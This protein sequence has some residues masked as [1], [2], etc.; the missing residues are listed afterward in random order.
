[1]PRKGTTLPYIL[2]EMTAQYMDCA[3]ISHSD[4]M[5][6]TKKCYL[7]VQKYISMLYTQILKAPLKDLA[8]ICKN[9]LK[10]KMA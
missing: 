4:K 9:L 1:M 10:L 7:L 8:H 5:K 3:T 2:C 6:S